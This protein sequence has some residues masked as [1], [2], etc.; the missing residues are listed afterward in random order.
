MDTYFKLMHHV[1]TSYPALPPHFQTSLLQDVA[2]AATI[3]ALLALSL[4]YIQVR[5]FYLLRDYIRWGLGGSIGGVGYVG[6]FLDKR[7][8][9]RELKLLLLGEGGEGGEAEEGRGDAAASGI[10]D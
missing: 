8:E 2:K 6:W 10:H 7:M 1:I 9:E 3:G 5:R 4:K